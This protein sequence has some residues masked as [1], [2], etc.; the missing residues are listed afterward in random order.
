LPGTQFD[1]LYVGVVLE[2]IARLCRPK[3]QGNT[4]ANGNSRKRL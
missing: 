3:A 1:E 4:V 2:S